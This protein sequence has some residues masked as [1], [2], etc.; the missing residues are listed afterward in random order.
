M[1]KKLFIIIILIIN[2]LISN[3]QDV[4]YGTGQWNYEGLGNHRAVI[5]VERDS[6][7]GII[8]GNKGSAI[9]L[10]G[11]QAR[12]EMETFFGQRVFLEMFVKVR[13]DWRNNENALKNFGYR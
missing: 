11:T 5:Y 13:K 9:K 7:K 8:I 2:V 4:F 12:I 1:E 6:Q 3:A 10:V